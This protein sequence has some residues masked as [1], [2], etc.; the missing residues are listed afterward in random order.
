MDD[1]QTLPNTRAI[2]QVGDRVLFTDGDSVGYAEVTWAYLPKDRVWG[3]FGGVVCEGEDEAGERV[4][5][6]ID[7]VVAVEEAGHVR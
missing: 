1:S 3:V 7:R 4:T 2:V 6:S 5:V